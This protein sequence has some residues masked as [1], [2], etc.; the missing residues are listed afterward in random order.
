M[1][2]VDIPGPSHGLRNDET[3]HQRRVVP[4]HSES[5]QHRLIFRIP[6]TEGSDD[7][8]VN[9][10]RVPLVIQSLSQGGVFGHLRS[11]R[12]LNGL[13]LVLKGDRHVNNVDDSCLLVAD[14]KVRL[15]PVVPKWHCGEAASQPSVAYSGRARVEVSP[16]RIRTFCTVYPRR[17]N[18]MP[19][20]TAKRRVEPGE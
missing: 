4:G 7:E 3:A 11:P 1:L 15:S 10:D 16:S 2:D 20:L 5:L 14:H 6:G 8:R 19:R 18:A 17:S 12:G 13:T 9:I